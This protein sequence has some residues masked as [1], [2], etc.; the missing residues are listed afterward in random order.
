[1]Q[2][3]ANRVLAGVALILAVLSPFIAGYPLLT[4]AIILLALA[5]LL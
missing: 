1:M 3:N 2:L 4:I 5:V